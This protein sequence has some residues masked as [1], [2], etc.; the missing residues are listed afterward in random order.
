M[1]EHT[2]HCAL[3]ACNDDVLWEQEISKE[4]SMSDGSFTGRDRP[5]WAEDYDWQEEPGPSTQPDE[6]DECYVPDN[7][8]IFRTL[9]WR[10]ATP[11]QREAMLARMRLPS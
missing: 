6:P 8:F 9:A 1:H 10:N 3:V 2:R 4:D 7:H 5:R 11:G